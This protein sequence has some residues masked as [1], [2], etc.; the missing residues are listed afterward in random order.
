MN[1]VIHFEIHADDP[2]RAARFYTDVFGWEIKKWEGEGVPMEYWMIMT[3]PEKE[4]GI[5]GGL[6]KRTEPLAG[7]GFRSYVCTVGVSSVDE[8]AEKI[9]KAGGMITVPKMA[10]PGVGWMAQAE[11]TDGNLFSL[12]QE[13]KSVG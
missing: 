1:R 12:M 7:T 5:D 4:P 11:D 6:M 10:M 13:D 2:A 9:K 3:G 8:H